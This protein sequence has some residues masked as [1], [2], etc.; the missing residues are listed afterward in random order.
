MLPQIVHC[1]YDEFDP[2]WQ[3]KLHHK[4]LCNALEVKV[5][6]SVSIEASLKCQSC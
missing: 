3:I 1:V 5:M 6:F 2:H 4:P